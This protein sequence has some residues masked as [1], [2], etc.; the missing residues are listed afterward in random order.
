MIVM[1][2]AAF[3]AR[4]LISRI[5][6]HANNCNIRRRYTLLR[7]LTDFRLIP[8][9]RHKINETHN[10][11]G[12]VLLFPYR[13]PD[14]AAGRKSCRW[15]VARQSGRRAATAR[16]PDLARRAGACPAGAHAR[17]A[18]RAGAPGATHRAA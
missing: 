3:M 17:A 14:G 15:P 11:H 1:S 12:S 8:S 2:F 6:N 18:R 13:R 4:S 16:T 7:V 10:R 5:E 9:C